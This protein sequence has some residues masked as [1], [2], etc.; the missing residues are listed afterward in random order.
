MW[1]QIRDLHACHGNVP[2][3]IRLL[4]LTEEVGEVAEAFIGMHGMFSELPR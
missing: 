3:E 2:L 4:K 1:D